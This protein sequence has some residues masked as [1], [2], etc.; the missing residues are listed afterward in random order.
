MRPT[1]IRAICL[2]AALLLSGALTLQ[3]DDWPHWRGPDRNGISRETDWTD[4]WPAAGAKIAWK[5]YVGAGFS[6]F[7][8]KDDRVFTTGNQDD[9]DTVYCFDAESGKELWSHTYPAPLD[10][11]FFSG[12]TTG[13]PTTDGDV[14]YQLSRRGEL[15]CFNAADGKVRWS[16]NLPEE[17]GVRIPGW[18]FAG[19]PLVDGERLLLSVGETGTALDKKTGKLIWKSDN[20]DAGYATPLPFEYQGKSLALIPSGK[21]YHLIDRTT[22]AEL[23]RHRWLTRFGV[24]A[25]DPIR[26]GDHVFISSGYN[27]GAALL[28]LGGDKPDVVWNNKE[29]QN[30]MNASVLIDGHLYGIDGDTTS[31]CFLKCVE[32]MTGE[33]RWSHEG[34]GSGALTAANGKLIV[35]TEEGTLMIVPATPEKFQTTVKAKVIPGPTWTVPV[36]ANGRIYCRNSEGDVVCLDVRGAK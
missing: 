4:D 7:V 11:K 14:L 1:N 6:S 8:V 18:G 15:F 9:E 29:L 2:V 23:W 34:V 5:A 36:L 27:R 20:K 17:T 12:G 26:S 3:A 31:D 25:A 32:L 28:K 24:N 22:G 19:A 13:T 21:F 35:L 16:K 10:A 33:V 30:Q